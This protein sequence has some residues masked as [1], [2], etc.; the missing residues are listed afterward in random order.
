M[1]ELWKAFKL[2]SMIVGGSILLTTFIV[3]FLYICII[4]LGKLAGTIVFFTVF[5]I[6]FIIALTYVF[7]EKE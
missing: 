3:F 6:G 2:A 5:I 4:L 7:Y 1:N